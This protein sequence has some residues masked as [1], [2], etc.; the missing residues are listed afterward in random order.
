LGTF[1]TAHSISLATTIHQARCHRCCDS[2]IKTGKCAGTTAGLDTCLASITG[3]IFFRKVVHIANE[4]SITCS[5][6]RILHNRLV[7][8][9]RSTTRL[10]STAV[11]GGRRADL[12]AGTNVAIASQ[13][14]EPTLTLRALIRVSFPLSGVVGV[15]IVTTTVEVAA[16]LV[17]CVT[18][19][20]LAVDANLLGSVTDGA[21]RTGITEIA[22]ALTRCSVYKKSACRAIARRC[23]RGPLGR[24]LVN[25][26]RVGT[27]RNAVSL[28]H[29]A[30]VKNV[31]DNAVH[32][33]FNDTT[34][35]GAN[36]G[37]GE[38]EDAKNR[39]GHVVSC[40]SLYR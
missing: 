27:L 34:G 13:V 4:A 5:H 36:N 38:E 40:D 7:N 31:A 22:A 14:G 39:D 26:G 9:R 29:A 33:A 21:L 17:R 18:E 6:N 24:S 23:R 20:T 19:P 37:R 10:A 1:S 15:T 8:A 16:G 25:G 3:W 2:A 28:Q 32:F 35:L 12:N 11:R 30:V